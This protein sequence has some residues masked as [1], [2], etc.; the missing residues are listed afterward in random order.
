M[1]FIVI[2]S[3]C[4]TSGT[5]PNVSP[6]SSAFTE[7]NADA[8]ENTVLDA[9][10]DIVSGDRDGLL[11]L[12]L[13]EDRQ[14]LAAVNR[15]DNAGDLMVDRLSAS[16]VGAF[17][18]TGISKLRVSYVGTDH[19]YYRVDVSPSASGPGLPILLNIEK[20]KIDL[21]ASFAGYV[22]SDLF[23][24]AQA[25]PEVHAMLRS[26]LHAL[27]TADMLALPQLRSQPGQLRALI[28]SLESG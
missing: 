28:R 17:G 5:T 23:A 6:S 27:K 26:R 1:I 8:M 4:S 25:D 11:S 7:E 16:L 18:P 13:N 19:D 22:A 3:S 12:T 14:F 24:A 2:A 10:M 9:L 15:Q 21:L 20:S